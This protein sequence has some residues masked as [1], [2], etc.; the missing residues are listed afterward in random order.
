MDSK[1]IEKINSE[2]KPPLMSLAESVEQ[3][4]KEL[5]AAKPDFIYETQIGKS[6]KTGRPTFIMNESGEGIAKI[7]KGTETTIIGPQ[8]RK[9]GQEYFV[10]VEANGS[11]G[12]M[13]NEALEKV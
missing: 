2:E 12:W 13:R 10:L 3:R 5:W 9:I 4:K 8:V 6:K 7:A 1:K 11:L